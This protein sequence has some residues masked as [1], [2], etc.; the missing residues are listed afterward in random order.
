MLYALGSPISVHWGSFYEPR[1]PGAWM[2]NVVVPEAALNARWDSGEVSTDECFGNRNQ[3]IS[4]AGLKVTSST[5]RAAARFDSKGGFWSR[6][7]WDY[8]SDPAEPV[9]RIRDEFNGP[10][11]AEP[12]IF[13]LALMATGPVE[14]ATGS[15]EV[16]VSSAPA[17]P[18]PGAPFALSPGVTRLG[19]KGQWG[20]DFDVFIIAET[21]QQATVTGWKQFWHPIREAGEYQHATG[22]KFEEAQYILRLRGTGAFDVLIVPYLRNKRPPDLAIVRT[23]DGMLFILRDGKTTTLAD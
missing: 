9:L 2:Q 5:A 3:T 1:M 11:A 10:S 14:T 12:K 7:V 15:R 23:S 6:R 20:V 22:K 16:P 17:K 13:S 21:F 19:F 4:A 8:R 18:P